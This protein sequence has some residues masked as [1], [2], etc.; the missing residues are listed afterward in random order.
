MHAL[1]LP[2]FW[3]WESLMAGLLFIHKLLGIKWSIQ[4]CSRWKHPPCTC[5]ISWCNSGKASWDTIQMECAIWWALQMRSRLSQWTMQVACFN[6]VHQMH[7][8]TKGFCYQRWVRLVTWEINN[9][10]TLTQ[11]VFTDQ[12]PLSLSL[13]LFYRNSTSCLVAKSLVVSINTLRSES[14]GRYPQINGMV[15]S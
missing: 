11:L 1:L 10:K 6:W 3:Q 13:S 7:I 4:T 15:A 14:V 9:T 5:C 8:L 12:F 2:C